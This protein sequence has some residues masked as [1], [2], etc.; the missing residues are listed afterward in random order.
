MNLHDVSI[1][2]LI[3]PLDHLAVVDRFAP[4]PGVFESGDEVLVNLPGQIL[5]G[6]APGDHER[7]IEIGLFARVL[8]VD[9]DDPGELV[10]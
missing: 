8:R 2:Q 5:Q 1:L 6:A 9:P 4:D 3:V 7:F 10:E